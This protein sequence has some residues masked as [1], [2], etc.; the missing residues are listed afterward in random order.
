MEFKLR[1]NII[2]SKELSIEANDLKEAMDK[3]QQMMIQGDLKLNDFKPS[4]MNY[5]ALNIT[6]S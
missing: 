1:A 6:V 5:E 2:M 3:A 4:S